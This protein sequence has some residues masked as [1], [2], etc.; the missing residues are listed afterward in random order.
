MADDANTF[1][2][3]AA[4]LAR[5]CTRVNWMEAQTSLQIEKFHMAPGGQEHWEVSDL[6]VMGTGPTLCAALDDAIGGKG[7]VVADVALMF[8]AGADAEGAAWSHDDI[9]RAAQSLIAHAEAAGVV[10]TIEQRPLEPLAMGHHETVVLMR[11]VRTPG[12]AG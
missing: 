10:L 5:D 12:A 11:T 8:E 3:R 1:G 9:L 7:Q 2:T 4:Q 6:E